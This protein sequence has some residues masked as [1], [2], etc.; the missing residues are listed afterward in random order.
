[1]KKLLIILFVISLCGCRTTSTSQRSY[2]WYQG[3]EEG[4]KDGR[5][6]G[7]KLGE[8]DTREKFLNKEDNNESD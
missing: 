8:M 1:M 4:H 7:Y 3:Y 5:W 2:D 6:M